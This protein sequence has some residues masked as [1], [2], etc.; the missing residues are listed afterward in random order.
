MTP[1]GTTESPEII[2][3]P[4]GFL[5]AYFRHLRRYVITGMLVWV[6]FIITLWVSWYLIVTFGFGIE[7]SIRTL[8]EYLN[9]LGERYP[10]LAFLNVVQYYQ[11]LGIILSFLLFLVTGFLTRY[12]VTRQMISAGEG[13]LQRIPIIRQVYSSTQQIRDVFTAREGGMIQR[14]VLVEFPLPGVLAIGFVMSASTRG[15]IADCVGSELVPVFLPTTPNPTSGYLLYYPPSAVKDVALSVEDALKIVV[16]G[17]AFN[18]GLLTDKIP[19][20]A[21]ETD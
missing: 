2:R 10:R 1:G 19:G 17:G 20:D 8:V 16:S 11:G 9:R 18:P 4:K 15:T 7:G 5:R 14:V 13:V 12:L 3:S 21:P 6:P